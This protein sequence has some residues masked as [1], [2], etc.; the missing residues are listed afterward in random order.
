MNKS[1]CA[2]AAAALCLAAGPASAAE[3]RSSPYTG[4]YW[5]KNCPAIQ[6]AFANPP[7]LLLTQLRNSPRQ[8]DDFIRNYSYC[9][10]T[11]VIGWSIT[12]QST[13]ALVERVGAWLQEHDVAL[14]G[15]GKGATFPG[16]LGTFAGNAG[17]L[18]NNAN[19]CL[20][21]QNRYF[22][23]DGADNRGHDASA[24]A[25]PVP[26]AQAPSARPLPPAPPR[27]D[28]DRARTVHVHE[29]ATVNIFNMAAEPPP[30]ARAQQTTTRMQ[31]WRDGLYY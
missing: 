18:A 30:A 13:C 7:G 21:L 29:G 2:V 17:D 14:S 20:V 31:H 25:T 16:A 11:N 5:E 26:A 9:N 19:D 23:G 8:A 6:Q 12:T 22:D 1:R 10:G 15:R 24:T 4:P 28:A 3:Y 27:A